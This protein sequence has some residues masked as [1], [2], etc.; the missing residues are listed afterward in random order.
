MIKGKKLL[1]LIPA[2]GGSKAVPRKNIKNLNGKP[3]MA[4]TIEAARK[5]RYIDKVV[6]STDDDE[7]MTI[8]KKYGSEAPFKRPKELASDNAK[9]MDVVLHCIKFFQNLDEEYDIIILLQP[10]SPLRGAYD[11]DKAIEYFVKK[12]ARAIVGVVKCEH[13]PQWAGVL[14]R[15]HSMKNFIPENIREKNRQ[16]IRT[17][18]RINGAVYLADIGFIINKRNWYGPKTFAYI[19]KRENSVDI[20]NLF[21]FMLAEFIMNKRCSL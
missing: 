16:E 1:A 3:L 4:W 21:D 15:D 7:I 2:R 8:A 13:S 5:S 10:T 19:M 18:Y 17:F 6:V 12:K 9:M 20:D 14:P 11:I